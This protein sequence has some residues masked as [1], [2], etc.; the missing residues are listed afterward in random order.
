MSTH[1]LTTTALVMTGALIAVL[2]LV[3][4]APAGWS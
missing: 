1:R 2:T 3:I 4:A